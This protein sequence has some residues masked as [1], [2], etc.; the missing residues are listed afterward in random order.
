M[1]RKMRT[2]KGGKWCIYINY[3]CIWWGSIGHARAYIICTGA[4]KVKLTTLTMTIPGTSGTVLQRNG[5][6]FG[7]GTKSKNPGCPGRF[8]DSWQLCISVR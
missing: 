5:H 4:Q 1:R 2:R 3:I 6:P 8:W 7:T